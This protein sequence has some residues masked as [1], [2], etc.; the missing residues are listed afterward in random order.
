MSL[1]P[2]AQMTKYQTDGLLLSAPTWE[3]FQGVQFHV[4]TDHHTGQSVP[5]IQ[6]RLP[7]KTYR[8]AQYRIAQ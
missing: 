1:V 5:R 8:T 4:Q 2:F 6:D 3:R 7:R